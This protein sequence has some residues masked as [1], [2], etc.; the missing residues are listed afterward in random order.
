MIQTCIFS[1]GGWWFSGGWW[2]NGGD[3]GGG[4]W[5]DSVF[6]CYGQRNRDGEG[7]KERE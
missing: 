3:G 1:T 6:G 7:K 2:F 4:G 5:F